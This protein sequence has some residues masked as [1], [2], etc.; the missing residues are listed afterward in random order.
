MAVGKG[1]E[2]A[3]RRLEAKWGSAQSFPT[4]ALPIQAAGPAGMGQLR[5]GGCQLVSPWEKRNEGHREVTRGDTH[6]VNTEKSGQG[7]P[8]LG[9]QP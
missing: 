2:L 8:L 7:A 5:A 1:R 4:A 9:P 6:G 3:G